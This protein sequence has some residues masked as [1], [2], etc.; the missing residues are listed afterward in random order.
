[1]KTFEDFLQEQSSNPIKA[2]GPLPGVDK[3]EKSGAQSRAI[4]YVKDLTPETVKKEQA[5]LA[6][7]VFREYLGETLLLEMPHISLDG[8]KQVC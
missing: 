7:I 5:S 6:S 2:L 1:M 3:V 8:R 4:R